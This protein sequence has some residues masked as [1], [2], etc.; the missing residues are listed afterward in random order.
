MQTF[1]IDVKIRIF[2]ISNILV[3]KRYIQILTHSETARLAMASATRTHIRG[4]GHGRRRY[5]LPF[6]RVSV[7][8]IHVTGVSG[9][10]IISS[11]I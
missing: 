10:Y 8:G 3:F 5:T 9:D 1:S 6:Q 11:H 7:T 4:P 2:I